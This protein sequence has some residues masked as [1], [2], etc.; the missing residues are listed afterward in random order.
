[1]AQSAGGKARASRCRVGGASGAGWSSKRINSCN[2]ST[3]ALGK[4]IFNKFGYV[5]IVIVICARNH[6]SSLTTINKSYVK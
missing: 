3:W 6:I 1:M 5:N 4:I 2:E